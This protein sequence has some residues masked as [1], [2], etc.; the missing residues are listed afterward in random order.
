MLAIT[1][2]DWERAVGRVIGDYAVDSL[3]SGKDI[4]LGLDDDYAVGVDQGN[5]GSAVSDSLWSQVVR[6]CSV[7]RQR[8]AAAES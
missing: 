1:Y 7:L 8:A 5:L 3:L 4:V 6:R 2:K